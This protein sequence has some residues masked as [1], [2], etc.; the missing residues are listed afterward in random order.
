[1]LKKGLYE[2]VINNGLDKEIN[3]D[4]DSKSQI[5]SIDKEEAPDILASYVSELVK[6]ALISVKDED[7]G[8]HKQIDLVNSLVKVLEK[9]NSSLLNDKLVTTNSGKAAQELL[10]VTSKK[11]NISVVDDKSEIVRPET[12]ISQSSLFT[13]A[14]EEPSLESEFC[15]EIKTCD[16]IDM[17]VS[18]VKWSGLRLIMQPL[19]DFTSHGGKLRVISTAY[20]GATDPKALEEL[21]KLQNTQIKVS[22]DTKITR[23]HAKAYIYYRETG[24]STAYVGSS[25]L[26]N[27]AMTN[28]LEW[29]IKVTKKDMPDIME[30]I[31]ASFESYWNSDSFETYNAENAPKFREVIEEES[32]KQNLGIAPF[33]FFDMRPYYFQ[34]EIL[35]A[36]QAE[37]TIRD[38]KKNLIVAATGTG[39]TVISAFD[40]KRFKEENPQHCRLLYIAHRDEILTQSIMTF[41]QVL[42]DQN[43]GDVWD[44]KQGK[45]QQIDY[46]FLSIQTLNS[47]DLTQ[48]LSPDYYDYIIVDEF[49]HAAAPTYQKMLNYFKPQILLGL[50]ATPERMDGKSI[51]GYFDNKIT[52]EIRLPEA[53]DRKLLSPFQYFGITDT[54]DLEDVKWV[55]GTYDPSELSAL[56]TQGS[57][58]DRRAGAIIS[59]IEKYVTDMDS[60]KGLGFCVSKEHAKFMAD[61]F[62]AHN[63]PSI[64]LISESSDEERKTAKGRLVKGEIKFI[65][66]VDI[67]NEGVDIPE[68]NTELFLRPTESLTIFLQQLGRGLR[69]ADKKECLTVLDF[70]GQANKQYNFE[71]K[72]SALMYNKSHGIVS[73]INNGFVHLPKGCFIQLEKIAQEHV[74]NNIKEALRL[75]SGLI[76]RIQH[77]KDLTGEDVT[78][79]GFADFYRLDVREIYAKNSFSRLKALAGVIPDFKEAME[80]EMTS[81]FKRVCAINSRHLISFITQALPHAGELWQDRLLPRR[82]RM[83]K[84]FFFT[85]WPEIAYKD[86]TFETINKKFVELRD[87]NPIMYAEL[88]E[89]LHYDYSKI[90]FLDENIMGEEYPLYLHCS[91]TR[92]QILVALDYLQPNSMRQGVFYLKDKKMDLLFNTLYKSEKDYSPSTMYK[93]YSINEYKF[94]WQSQSTTSETSITGQRYIN[95]QAMGSQVLLFVRDYDNDPILKGTSPFTFLGF[96]NYESHEGSY[97]MTIIWDLEKPIPAQFIAKTNKLT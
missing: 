19:I 95:H 39:K 60:V 23:L 35:D 58:A 31:T 88:L 57:A 45:P 13:G 87:N 77:Y 73:E 84:M 71:E 56:Y 1:M 51:L 50:T 33:A 82:Q 24:F 53:I 38:N 32:K 90:D 18:F 15:K 46:L 96:A 26:S 8:L 43:F 65:F 85:L 86:C 5:E 22:Y 89:L 78:L 54:V 29:N 64:Y 80:D 30:K 93:D 3:D 37:R 10:A 94:H 47:Q 28:G 55:R 12:P 20:M 34:Q 41:R 68:V 7:D 62:N 67:Y 48:K 36:I 44:S 42:R 9:D 16:R 70:I 6:N 91:Y 61:Y 69:H 17:L 74:L 66:V 2:Q 49:H 59:S 72:Y 40:Y 52:A 92:D 81:A 76:Y 27:P 79:K 83:L 14:N 11:D 97:P 25:N 21:L 75:S 63:I 4:K